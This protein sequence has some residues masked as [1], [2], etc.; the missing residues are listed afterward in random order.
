MSGDESEGKTIE[1]ESTVDHIAA[2]SGDEGDV[3]DHTAAMSGDESEG[4]TIGSESESTVDTM[5]GDE[6]EA[7]P[8]PCEAPGLRQSSESSWRGWASAIG[9]KILEGVFGRLRRAPASDDIEDTTRVMPPK[10]DDKI[11]SRKEIVAAIAHR[12]KKGPL[13]MKEKAA[14]KEKEPT[15]DREG[16][17]TPS[18]EKTTKKDCHALTQFDKSINKKNKQE[19]YGPKK[20]IKP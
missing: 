2:M 20:F 11:L 1:T 14:T 12:F 18:K 15:T 8:S 13:R 4:E 10:R 16:E 9:R 19:E 6:G 3:E 5:S 7:I 17:T